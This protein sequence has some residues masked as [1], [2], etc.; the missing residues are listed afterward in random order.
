MIQSSEL[1]GTDTEFAELLMARF[2]P[3][4]EICYAPRYLNILLYPGR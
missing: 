4:Q 2:G 1:T 3:L